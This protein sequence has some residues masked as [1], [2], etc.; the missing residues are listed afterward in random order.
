MVRP[1]R[2]LIAHGVSTSKISQLLRIGLVGGSSGRG[3]EKSGEHPVLTLKHLDAR[4]AVGVAI[5][6]DQVVDELINVAY[7]GQYFTDRARW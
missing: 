7:K 3:V 6:V 1:I 2:R 5:E 4:D